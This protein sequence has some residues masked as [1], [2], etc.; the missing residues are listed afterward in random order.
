ML[1]SS[2]ARHSH[3]SFGQRPTTRTATDLM[4]LLLS[5]SQLLHSHFVFSEQPISTPPVTA[6]TPPLPVVSSAYATDSM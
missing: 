6:N 4:R 3:A 1:L 2:N 5:L